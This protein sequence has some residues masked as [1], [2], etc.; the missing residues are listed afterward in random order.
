MQLQI[1]EFNIV[2]KRKKERKKTERHNKLQGWIK[3]SWRQ[4]C[5]K[6]SREKNGGR[7]KEWNLMTKLIVS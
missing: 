4:S 6:G 3:W 2:A 7:K 5:T 1:V